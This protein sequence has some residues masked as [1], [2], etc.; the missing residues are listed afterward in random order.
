MAFHGGSAIAIALVHR[1]AAVAVVDGAAVAAAINRLAAVNRSAVVNMTTAVVVVVVTMAAVATMATAIAQAM[2]QPT[3]M[4]TTAATTTIITATTIAAV[5]AVTGHSAVVGAQQGDADHL[6]EDRDAKNQSTIH[7]GSSK[8][9]S[10]THT[11][12]EFQTLSAACSASRNLANG[13]RASRHV[14][15]SCHGRTGHL[16]PTALFSQLLPVAENRSDHT[17]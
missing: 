5:A 14:P 2:E 17:V 9:L 16:R 1:A 10:S 12:Q 11:C 3:T 7:L 4:A 8:K 15:L 6:E 13:G